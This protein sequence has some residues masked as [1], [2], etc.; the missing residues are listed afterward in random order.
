[1][2][3]KSRGKLQGQGKGPIL[4]GIQ[5]S[6]MDCES[7]CHFWQG[8]QEVPSWKRKGKSNFLKMNDQRGN[9]VENKGPGLEDRGRSGN[10]YENKGDTSRK[11]GMLL[12]TKDRA[13]KT[14][15]EA[16]MSMKTKGILAEKRECC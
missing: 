13:W 4:L 2:W 3:G 14:A 1:M 8:G 9:V 11:A 6:K 16:G 5:N 15:G 10:V 12:K 7:P